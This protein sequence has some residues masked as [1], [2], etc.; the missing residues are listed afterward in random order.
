MRKE[1]TIEDCNCHYS[2]WKHRFIECKFH[3]QCI[4]TPC[5]PG[6]NVCENFTHMKQNGFDM[7][8]NYIG[9]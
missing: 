8:G 1:L 7:K 4:G 2:W 3:K 5:A 9:K 6:I